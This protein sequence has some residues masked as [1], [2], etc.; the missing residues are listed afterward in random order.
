[1]IEL[2]A[3]RGACFDAPENSLQ[4]FQIAMDQGARRIEFDVQLTRDG[5]P[6]VC[7]DATTERMTGRHL[8]IEFS[9]LA[10]IRDLRLTNG[11]LIPTLDEACALFS[12]KVELD[13]E[14]KTSVPTAVG[15]IMKVLDRHDIG[16]DP[17]ITSFDPTVLLGVHLAGFRGRRG[18]LIGS[19][20]LNV[21][22]RY[23]EAWPMSGLVS[24]RAT[25]LVIH[26]MLAHRA[27]RRELQRR[28]LGLSLWTSLE[29][30]QKPEPQRQE[31]YQKLVNVQPASIIV[32][33]VAECLR[34]VGAQLQRGR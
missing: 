17:F 28:G 21:R 20:S 15:A 26:H 29:D 27:L 3:H 16:T 12:G 23:Y 22:Q 4:A 30:E 8:E 6:I 19:K 9:T 32:A 11:E 13:L 34:N 14:I 10:E 2:I 24:S 1:M 5:V 18:L 7:H 33:R 25:D 31:L